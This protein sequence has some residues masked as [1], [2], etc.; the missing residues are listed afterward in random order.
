MSDAPKK[1]VIGSMA[2]AGIVA[3]AAI[4][5]LVIGVPFTGTSHSRLMDI[6]FIVAAGIVGYL[7]WDAYRDLR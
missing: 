6:L 7:S 3:L 4:A 2:V 1:M 5:D